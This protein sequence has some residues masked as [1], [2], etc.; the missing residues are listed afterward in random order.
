MKWSR[1]TYNY[2]MALTSAAPA[3]QF[4][5]DQQL[6]EMNPSWRWGLSGQVNYD[7]SGETVFGANLAFQF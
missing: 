6:I 1:Q 7:G 3:V 4:A 5:F 2:Q